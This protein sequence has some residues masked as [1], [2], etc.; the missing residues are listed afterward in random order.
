MLAVMWAGFCLAI[1][2]LKE[3]LNGPQHNLFVEQLGD[4]PGVVLDLD[5]IDLLEVVGR[6]G[7]DRRSILENHIFTFTDIQFLLRELS[8]RP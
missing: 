2:G 3:G 6:N 4:W 5:T 1:A 7:H 8:G